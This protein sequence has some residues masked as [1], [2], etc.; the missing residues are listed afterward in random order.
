MRVRESVDYA[1]R[2]LM[3]NEVYLSSLMDVLKG[4]R[5]SFDAGMSSCQ[6]VLTGVGGPCVGPS[7][8]SC[9]VS[10]SHIPFVSFRVN[11]DTTHALLAFLIT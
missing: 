7:S 3:K 1:D 8:M 2:A 6:A 9:A 5:T 4:E 11:A 10:T